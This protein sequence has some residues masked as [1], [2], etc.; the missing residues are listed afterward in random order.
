MNIFLEKSCTEC[1]G[2]ASLKPFCK[3]TKLSMSGSTVWNV[4]KFY[5]LYVQFEVYKNI[6]KVRFDHLIL[7]YLELVL[8]SYFVHD[9]W[10]KYFSRYILTDQ[11]SLPDWLYFLRYWAIYYCNYL[12]HPVCND[13]NF[14]I[15]LA[16]FSTWPICQNKNKIS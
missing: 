8:L 9:F 4:L 13:V 15:N 6:F 11:I 1:G 16:F 10:R 12:F 7:P 3:K 14:E 2:K 5:L